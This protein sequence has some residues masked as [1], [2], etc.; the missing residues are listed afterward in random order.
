[1]VSSQSKQASIHVH[2]HVHN[3]VT[4]ISM[5][6]AQAC[7]INIT[8]RPEEA[9]DIKSRVLITPGVKLWHIN[10]P[11]FTSYTTLTPHPLTA[12][13]EGFSH[14]HMY[15]VSSVQYIC[16]HKLVFSMFSA[17]S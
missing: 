13:P 8:H 10:K 5:G 1:M 12:A 17:F 9:M 11:P 7:P 4:S 3:A 14:I 16:T 15:V 6:L 2:L